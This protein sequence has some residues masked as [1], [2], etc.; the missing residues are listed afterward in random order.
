M[1]SKA[2]QTLNNEVLPFL[3]EHNTPIKTIL[4]DNGRDYCGRKDQHP[5]ELF[6]QLKD[7]EH[8][9]TKVKRP[10]SIEFVE[11][12]HRT[13]IDEHFRDAGSTN[14]YETV[15]EMEKD[16]QIYLNLYNYERSY[17]CRNMNGRT[18]YQVSKK[19]YEN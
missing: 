6:L 19:E 5:F 10:Q 15:D 3:E 17:Q 13:L 7:I 11:R 8:R 2:V 9:I 1:S 18:P 4:T 16:F 14:F 12:L